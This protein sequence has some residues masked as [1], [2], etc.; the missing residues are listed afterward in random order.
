MD[1][2]RFGMMDD[3]SGQALFITS[4]STSFSHLALIVTRPFSTVSTSTTQARR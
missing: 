4:K 1:T 2:A 3:L